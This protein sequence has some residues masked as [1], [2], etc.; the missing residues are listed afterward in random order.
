VLEATAEL[1]GSAVGPYGRILLCH[2]LMRLH[3]QRENR[4][5]RPRH[6]HHNPADRLDRSRKGIGLLQRHPQWLPPHQTGIR[7]TLPVRGVRASRHTPSAPRLAHPSAFHH[8]VTG[9]AVEV[10]RVAVIARDP[11]ALVFVCRTR[12]ADTADTAQYYQQ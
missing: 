3:V 12:A 7:S 11:C 5:H 10:L 6:K 8:I 4:L 9:T 2:N 1:R